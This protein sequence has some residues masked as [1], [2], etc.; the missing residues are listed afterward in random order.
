M[1]EGYEKTKK[2][3]TKNWL[4]GMRKSCD[5]AKQ[6]HR[7]S[8][9]SLCVKGSSGGGGGQAVPGDTRGYHIVVRD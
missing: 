9:G 1:R 4:N 5:A 3:T 7:G 8:S 6:R 2:T